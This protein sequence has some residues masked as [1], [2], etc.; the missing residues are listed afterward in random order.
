MERLVG[1]GV[2]AGGLEVHGDI[3]G[4]AAFATVEEAGELFSDADVALS[5]A[6]GGLALVEDLAEEAVGEDVEGGAGAVGQLVLAGPFEEV[7][8]AAEG[9]AGVF[10]KFLGKREC[11]GNGPGG[12]GDLGEGAGF[13]DCLFVGGKAFEF[14]I[15]HFSEAGGDFGIHLRQGS[16]LG[17]EGGGEGGALGGGLD[18]EM[19][20]DEV[21]KDGDG[22]EWGL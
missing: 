1:T 19:L 3:V 15:D 16:R 6:G 13:E 18:E 9:V 14:E 21:L 10:C 4:D 17:P 11:R 20:G 2:V 5:A 22:E 12:E 7:E 8:S